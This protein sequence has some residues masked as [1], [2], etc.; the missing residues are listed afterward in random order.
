[1][2][3]R[4]LLIS[5]AVRLSV[6]NNQ[7]L[8]ERSQEEPVLL[9]IEDISVLVLETPQALVTSALL[10]KL[11][12][13]DIACITCDESH[14]PNGVL[15]PFMQHSRTLKV[16]EAQL[17]MT[18][19]QKKRAWQAIVQ[20]KLVNQAACLTQ[21]RKEGE[22]KLTALSKQVK[23][24]D[25]DNREAVGARMYFLRLYGNEFT[26][27]KDTVINA[28]LNYGY[29][30]FRAA[31]ARS[32]AYHGFLPAFGLQHSNQ[33]NSFNL[34]DDLLEAFR[35]IVDRFVF[36]MDATEKT[37]LTTAMKAELVR[38]L[39]SDVGTP[40]GIMSVL[41]AIDQTVASLGRF[42]QSGDT[43]DLELPL[44]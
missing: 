23:S 29:A 9:P 21:C 27:S 28:A 36:Y 31:M 8:L 34:A 17:A 41:S 16:M 32:L 7:L 30:I 10:S 3:W 25:P 35:P 43:R 20:Q 44:L 2:G 18:Q 37:E 22:N 11:C 4:S 24:G 1:M 33:L 12:A 5:Q 38:L 15:L 13:S 39:H 6:K 42:A 19:P 14:L 40:G 26:R